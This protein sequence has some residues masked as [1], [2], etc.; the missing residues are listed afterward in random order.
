[1]TTCIQDAVGSIGDRWRETGAQ[2]GPLGCPIAAETVDAAGNRT[3]QFERGEIA[4]SV[5][6]DM[7]VTCYRLRD[8]ACFEW[9]LASDHYRYKYWQFE[10]FI[11]NKGLGLAATTFFFDEDVPHRLTRGRRTMRIQSAGRYEFQVRGCDDADGDTCRQGYTKRIGFT[12]GRV[13]VSPFPDD[14]PVEGLIADRW[15]LYDAWAGP[16][17]RPAGPVIAQPNGQLQ[18]NFSSGQISV[19]PRFGNL[20]SVVYAVREAIFVSWGPAAYP[21]ADGLRPTHYRLEGFREMTPLFTEY[22]Q[23]DPAWIEFSCGGYQFDPRTVGATQYQFHL[24]P[25]LPDSP[26]GEVGPAM[27]LMSVGFRP[28]TKGFELDVTTVGGTPARAVATDTARCRAVVH[29][30]ATTT[31]VRPAQQLYENEDLGAYLVAH[32]QAIRNH[33]SSLDDGGHLTY[34]VPGD[35]L[36]QVTIVNEAILN[37]APGPVGT[38]SGEHLSGLTVLYCNKL[39]G[40]YDTL[41]KHLVAIAFRYDDLLQPRVRAHLLDRLLSMRGRHD[42]SVEVRQLCCNWSELGEVAVAAAGTIVGPVVFALIG[43]PPC[44][45]IAES[46]NHLLLIES[47]RYLTNQLLHQRDPRIEYDNSRNGL[48]EWLLGRLQVAARHDFLE[49]NSRPYLRY[50]T[51]ALLN[52]EEFADPEV[53]TAARVLLD[54]LMVKFAV[55]SSELRRLGPFRRLRDNNNAESPPDRNNFYSATSD[56]MTGFFHQYAGPPR[57]ATG[58]PGKHMP[59]LWYIECL[60]VGLARYRPPAAAYVLAMDNTWSG[61]HLFHHG[62]RP[63]IRAGEQADAGVEIY[64]RS[65]SFLLTAG[66]VFLNSGYGHD[67]IVE[68]E[69]ASGPQAITLLPTRGNFTFEQLIRLDPWPKAGSAVNTAVWRGFAC[70]ANLR[71][72]AWLKDPTVP[73]VGWYFFDL[74]QDFPGRGKLGLHVVVLVTPP[75]EIFLD[76][77]HD[78]DWPTNWAFIYAMEATLGF[79]EFRQRTL[80]RNRDIIAD[81]SYFRSGIDYVFNSPDGHRIEFVIAPASDR[82]WGAGFVRGDRYSSR[83]KRFGDTILEPDLQRLPLAS[84]EYLRSDGHTGRF[85]IRYPGCDAPLVLDFR[86]PAHAERT[87][88][89]ACPAWYPDVIR[90]YHEVAQK[91]RTVGRHTEAAGIG[92]KALQAAAEI[93]GLAAQPV[94]AADVAGNL[95]FIGAYLEAGEEAVAVTAAGTQLLRD[96]VIAQPGNAE[97]LNSLSWALHNLAARHH[98]AGNAPGA[99]GLGTEAAQLPPRF[100]LAAATPSVR[101]HVASNLT[102][103]GA[104]LPAGDE[105]VDVTIAA[106]RV[107][108]ELNTSYPSDSGYLDSLSW[109]LHNLAARHSG[110]GNPGAA[111]GLGVEAADLP[112]RFDATAAPA[113]V[114]AHVAANLVYVG[115]YLPAGEEAVDVTTAGTQTFRQLNVDFPDDPAYLNT[116]SWALHNLAARHHSAGHPH[117]AV[118]LGTEAAQLTARFDTTHADHLTRAS[119]A[120]NLVYI[121]AYLPAGNEAVEVTATAVRIYQALTAAHPE[122]PDYPVN[123]AWAQQNLAARVAAAGAGPA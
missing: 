107:Y 6:Q 4:W 34:A 38:D 94:I 89:P 21:E 55:S 42:D 37:L 121:G 105:A 69:N 84:G 15:H 16:L 61:T 35:R 22:L 32:L 93:R 52:L 11:D 20:V 9:Q 96:L 123:L 44:L 114:K 90:A 113:N 45:E 71:I 49:F 60:I 43:G 14:A 33:R 56:P 51:N 73:L 23:P 27:P 83:I 12:V 76:G 5:A 46:E 10:A 24:Y 80:D 110:A 75:G 59:G 97:Y 106:V 100:E 31:T 79:D 63:V 39:N 88:E 78:R 118:G 62:S 102:Y 104:Y 3:Q 116:F 36:F 81:S 111:V 85:E 70:G 13:G 119:V 40:E 7:I 18:Q 120:S 50:T 2:Y 41:L 101:A 66:G 98:S 1:M 72:P 112:K 92:R 28:P 95:I 87:G 103:V 68:Y 17:G 65:P 25:G 109:A 86:N 64:Y 77:R 99:A 67:E 8:Y 82:A 115:A 47:A 91:L 58:E 19:D 122:N 54:Y 53:S 29:A 48:R 108:R 57:T 30:V 26:V 74:N 117:G